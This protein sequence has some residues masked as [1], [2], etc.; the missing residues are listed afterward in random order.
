VIDH[1][2]TSEPFDATIVLE[3]KAASTTEI[4]YKI[5]K[6]YNPKAIDLTIATLIFAGLMTDS[7]ALSFSSA[8]ADSYRIASE[9]VALGVDNYMIIRRLIKETSPETFDLT[10]GALSR[11]KFFLEGRLGIIAFSNSDFKETGSAPEDTEGVINRIIDITTVKV[12]VSLAEI[13]ENAYKV[14]IRS[15]DG[16]NSA[17]IAGEFGGGGHFYASGCRIYAPY[18]E[19]VKKIVEAVNKFIN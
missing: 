8:T 19:A 11:A 12:A 18:D 10:N 14:G 4:L 2:Q 7:G 17:A 13:G 15:K 9:L 6:E 3:T 5:F 1:H 16:V